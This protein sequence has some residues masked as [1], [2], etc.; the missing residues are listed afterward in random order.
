MHSIWYLV[1]SELLFLELQF[2]RQQVAHPSPVTSKG[3]GAP[4]CLEYHTLQKSLK[5]SAWHQESSER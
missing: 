5:G 2:Q 1:P 3:L 4:E